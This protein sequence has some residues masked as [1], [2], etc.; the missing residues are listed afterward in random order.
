MGENAEYAILGYALMGIVLAGMVGWIYVRY[1]NLTR[2]QRLIAQIEAEEAQDRLSQAVGA[3]E[4]DMR[5]ESATREQSG[6]ASP[7]SERARSLPSEGN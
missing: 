5:P 6:M 1:V 7:S 4:E 2:E 3:V